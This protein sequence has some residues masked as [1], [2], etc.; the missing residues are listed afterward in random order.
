MGR[1]SEG[2]KLR[3]DKK[4]PYWFVQFTHEGRKYN[5][6]TGCRA[7]RAAAQEA[8]KIYT[9]VVGGRDPR[10]GAGLTS[11]NEL[12]G[13]LAQWLV[14]VDET[15]SEAWHETL[16]LYA[17]TH[18]LSRWTRL[19]DVTTPAVQRYISERLREPGLRGKTISPVTLSKEL[20]GL[21]C[22]LKWC[23]RHGY[24]DDL[25]T[26]EAPEAISDY[27]PVSLSREEMLK[28][29]AQLPPRE[30]HF[31]RLPV[32]AYFTVMWATSFRRGTMARIRWE[33]MDL[34]ASAVSVRASQDKKR[35]SR[36][37]PLTAEAVDE[38]RTIAPGVGLVFGGHEYRQALRGAAKR[39]GLPEEVYSKLGNHSVRHSRLTDLASRTKNI[40]A[41]QYMAGHKD[42]ASTMRY[43]HGSLDNARE[44]LEE[45]EKDAD[46]VR[47]A[48][49]KEKA[50]SNESA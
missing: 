19:E 27:E 24:L 12:S 37:V 33:D 30:R 35:Y 34:E 9:A 10:A 39:A 18:W 22:F 26:W 36:V 44:M 2:W 47:I 23:K 38:L 3:Q 1:R 29:L 49:E 8:A 15:K 14:E 17:S 41:I 5:R 32:R 11:R 50:D 16:E 46:N 40:A 21:R 20:S 28:V 45:V 4:S 7:K 48:Y 25:P 13:L 42:L 43:V 6:S 31:M